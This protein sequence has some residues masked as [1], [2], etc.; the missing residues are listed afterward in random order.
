M[1]PIPRLAIPCLINA[2]LGSTCTSP[3]ILPHGTGA[4]NHVVN[5]HFEKGASCKS[6]IHLFVAS[7][8]FIQAKRKEVFSFTIYIFHAEYYITFDERVGGVSKKFSCTNNEISSKIDPP[9]PLKNTKWL[10]GWTVSALFSRLLLQR[11][12]IR[13]SRLATTLR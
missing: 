9:L 8:L 1:V 5:S 6:Y 13:D 10:R 3:N 11:T 7:R 4:D 2:L 12:P